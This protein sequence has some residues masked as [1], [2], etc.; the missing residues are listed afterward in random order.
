LEDAQALAQAFRD[1]ARAYD[2]LLQ[3]KRHY[4]HASATLLDVTSETRKTVDGTLEGLADHIRGTQS[5]AYSVVGAGLLLALVVAGLVLRFVVR[6]VIHSVRRMT[7]AS[8]Y[9][10]DGNLSF[11]MHAH[12]AQSTNDELV[13]LHNNM[14]RMKDSLA[15][16]LSEVSTTASAL[17]SQA[18]ELSVIATQTRNNVQ[19]QQQQTQAVASA[20]TELSASSREV[21]QA[22][23]AAKH[24]A[25]DANSESQGGL[26]TLERLLKSMDTLSEH[27]SL[28]AGVVTQL[29][30][31]SSQ[32]GEVLE[33]ISSIADQTNLLALNAAIEA[34]RAGEQGRGFAVVA[35]EVRTL[36]QKTQESTEEIRS[37]VEALQNRTGQAHTRMADSQ[38]QTEQARTESEHVAQALQAIAEQADSIAEQNIQVA[39]AVNQQEQAIEEISRSINEIDGRTGETAEAVNQTSESSNELARL[40]ARLNELVQHFRV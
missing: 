37:V 18:E 7:Q 13:A 28:T 39:A 40:A 23:E 30:Q 32:I 19:E 9:I 26:R 34:A 15:G 12:E 1:A 3:A 14:V 11:E 36:A 24:A 17:A 5:F 25:Q 20:V 10:A 35:D 22:T 4:N 29:T 33:V 21:A 6:N 31:D 8:Q 38:A 27:V 2:E 16:L